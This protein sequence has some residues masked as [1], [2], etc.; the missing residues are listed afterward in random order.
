MGT[1]CRE[2]LSLWTNQAKTNLTL[3]SGNQSMTI[4]PTRQQRDH[5]T[6][7]RGSGSDSVLWGLWWYIS[8]ICVDRAKQ[9]MNSPYVR[10]SFGLVWVFI[11]SAVVQCVLAKLFKS[12]TLFSFQ[13]MLVSRGMHC[14]YLIS[15]RYI[16]ELK[17][18]KIYLCIF[19]GKENVFYSYTLS[20]FV[21]DRQ[22]EKCV[23][24]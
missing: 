18:Y 20:D 1:G 3:F 5:F 4:S 24:P 15:H 6:V 19:Q 14:Q 7:G 16:L 13:Y 22:F 17:T 12:C 23:K 10:S 21:S 11:T 8:P 9:E 2:L